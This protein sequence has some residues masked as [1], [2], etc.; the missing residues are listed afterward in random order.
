MKAPVPF[1]QFYPGDSPVHRL[2]PRAKMGLVAAY[3]VMLFTVDGFAGLAAATA[4]AALAVAVSSVPSRLVLRGIRAV[5]IILVFTLLAHGLRW[6]PA[7]VTLLRVGPVALDAQGLVTGLFFVVRI[8]LLVVGTSLLTLTTSPVRLADGLERLMRP[9]EVLR[10][11]AGEVA[12][13]LTVALR[14]IPTTAEEAEKIVVAQVARGARFDTGG[15]L[16]R[17]RA[18]VPV[19]VPL[20][21]NLFRR[22]DELATAMEARCYRGG[23][24]RT[25]FTESR[26]TLADRAALLVGAALMIVVGVV[27]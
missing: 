23:A 25:R 22:A 6:N 8:V 15:L 7:T 17:A 19:L 26:M 3:M 21:V 27:L 13:M 12:M 18:Y 20:F 10:F 5:S 11:P 9:L 1:G 24:G 14:F 4:V 2:E 16:K